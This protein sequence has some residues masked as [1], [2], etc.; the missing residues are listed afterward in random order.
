MKSL[1]IGVGLVALICA[2]FGMGWISKPSSYQYTFEVRDMSEGT[3]NFM[4]LELYKT[5]PAEPHTH[6]PST[7]H[8][9]RDAL[10]EYAEKQEWNVHAMF[11]SE[12]GRSVLLAIN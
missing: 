11:I 6:F 12:D 3:R 10:R 5:D 9:A 2:G 1:L 7:L 8:E 4:L